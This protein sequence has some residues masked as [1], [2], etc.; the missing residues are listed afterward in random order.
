MWASPETP[1]LPKAPKRVPK[2]G[3]RVGGFSM[4]LIFLNLSIFSFSQFSVEN[5]QNASARP[6]PR[7]WRRHEPKQRKR[8]RK[9]SPRK[10]VKTNLVLP[11]VQ[12]ERR[13][14]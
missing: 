7:N 11:S 3:Q 4:F 2:E 1:S 9:L 12:K 8:S 13:S 14:R 10:S 6:Q 5:V